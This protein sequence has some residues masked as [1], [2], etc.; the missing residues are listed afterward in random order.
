[1]SSLKA[2]GLARTG[3]SDRDA[4]RLAAALRARPVDSPLEE[5]EV[6]LNGL[7]AKATE[8]VRLAV[9]SPTAPHDRSSSFDDDLE[10]TGGRGR[11]RP[12]RRQRQGRRRDSA[13]PGGYGGEE[14][15]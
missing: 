12:R 9:K 7:S 5:V 15:R 6:G 14:P 10:N 1:C 13:A 4:A 11:Q 3:L 2:L 8:A